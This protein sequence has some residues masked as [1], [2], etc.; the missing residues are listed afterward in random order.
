MKAKVKATG[1]I[2]EV[3]PTY[4]MKDRSDTTI[5]YTDGKLGEWTANDLDFLPEKE[6]VVREGFVARD[7]DGF[8]SVYQNKPT[9]DE[10]DCHGF[11]H[12]DNSGSH[13]DLPTDSFP[14]V[15]WQNE[16]KRVRITIEE[17]EE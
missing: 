4:S 2:I 16:P 12:D 9:R 8:I 14:S 3:T 10:Y 11:W 5:Y 17:I 6:T 1:E 13:I 15:T 7:E